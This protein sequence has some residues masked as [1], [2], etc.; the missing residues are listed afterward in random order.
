LI[1]LVFNAGKN[2]GK[3]TL[4][5]HRNSTKN[6]LKFSARECHILTLRLRKGGVFTIPLP[7]RITNL[8]AEYTKFV[9]M[10]DQIT[11]HD[12]LVYHH[13]N[14]KGDKIEVRKTSGISETMVDEIESDGLKLYY[15][16]GKQKIEMVHSRCQ[17][18]G[19]RLWFKCPFCGKRCGKLYRP[20]FELEYACRECHVLVYRSK[21][22]SSTVQE[23]TNKL[24][25]AVELAKYLKPP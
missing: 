8:I 11:P 18:G 1:F 19:G 3:S 13:Y 23:I 4:K 17:K 12:G 22:K 2:R 7:K 24:A 20:F 16:K 14:V 21:Q 10:A 25:I 9:D 6:L 5:Q 15:Q